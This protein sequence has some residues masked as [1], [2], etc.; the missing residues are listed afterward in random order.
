MHLKDIMVWLRTHFDNNGKVLFLP[1][2]FFIAAIEGPNI[3]NPCL[4][5]FCLSGMFIYR[6]IYYVYKYKPRKCEVWPQNIHQ[7][8][9]IFVSTFLLSCE[10]N[11]DLT[12]TITENNNCSR[13]G[14]SLACPQKYTGA[15]SISFGMS[16][17]II[18]I[19]IHCVNTEGGSWIWVG[20]R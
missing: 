5:I 12:F 6:Y 17:T 13:T 11:N 14:D 8:H 2:F 7:H 19:M 10:I 4:W 9:V 16:L 1:S 20:V 15:V 18:I 3:V